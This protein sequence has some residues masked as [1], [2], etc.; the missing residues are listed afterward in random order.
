MSLLATFSAKDSLSLGEHVV[1]LSLLVLQAPSA[2]LLLSYSSS[3]AI[4]KSTSQDL[5]EKNHQDQEQIRN[6]LYASSVK[7]TSPL[8]QNQRRPRRAFL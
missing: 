5:N 4:I 8:F 6:K 2:S 7:A 1:G 3:E